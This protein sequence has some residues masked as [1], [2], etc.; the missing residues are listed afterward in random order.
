MTT[1]IKAE[2]M[3]MKSSLAKN[4]LLAIPFL[5]FAVCYLFEYLC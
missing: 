3:K 4:L 5:L 1:F 2:L